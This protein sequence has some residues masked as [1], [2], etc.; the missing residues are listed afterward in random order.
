MSGRRM[1]GHVAAIVLAFSVAACGSSGTDSD[2][3]PRS[4]AGGAATFTATLVGGG[5]FD[6]AALAGRPVAYWFWAPT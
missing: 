5:T 3:A 2:S 4:T 1:C 6:S